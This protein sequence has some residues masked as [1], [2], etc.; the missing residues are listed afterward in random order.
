MRRLAGICLVGCLVLRASTSALGSTSASIIDTS[1]ADVVEV[2][3]APPSPGT[4]PVSQQVQVKLP[5]PSANPLWGIPIK[6]LSGTRDRPIFSSSRRPPPPAVVAPPV[7]AVPAPAQKPKEAE[8]PQLSLLGTIVNGNDGF[9]IFMDQVT[10]APVRIRIGA[11]YQG[12]TLSSIHAG[13]AS[14]E[15]GRDSAVLAFPNPAG[16]QKGVSQVIAATGAPLQSLA[17]SFGFTGESPTPGE[18]PLTGT[19][20]PP[21]RTFRNAP[22]RF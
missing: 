7:A 14:L 2:V 18:P 21:G 5:A 13:A 9:G 12:W 19:V 17:P 15:R 3:V 20:A 10:K 11:S 1:N 6:E 4:A 22:H 8:R 16:G